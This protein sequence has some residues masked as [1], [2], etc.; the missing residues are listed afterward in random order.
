LSQLLTYKGLQTL[1]LFRVISLQVALIKDPTFTFQS[2]LSLNISTLIPLPNIDHFLSHSCIETLELEEL[3]PHPSHIQA[4]ILPQAIFTWYTYCS[5]LHE[6]A[7]RAGY[8]IV[9]DTEV[10]EAQALLAHTTN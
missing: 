1:P 10:V 2:C 5:F 7:R 4:G 3:L 8:A 6:G 9:S